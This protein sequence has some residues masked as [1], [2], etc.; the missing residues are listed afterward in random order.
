MKILL[1]AISFTLFSCAIC[2][3]LEMEFQSHIIFYVIHPFLIIL[4]LHTV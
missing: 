2:C 1:D 3:L 4:F